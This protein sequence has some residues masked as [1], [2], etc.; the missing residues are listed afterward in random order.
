MTRSI[1]ISEL[2]ELIHALEMGKPDYDGEDVNYDVSTIENA[3][4]V[5]KQ[6]T[7]ILRKVEEFYAKTKRDNSFNTVDELKAYLTEYRSHQLCLAN[8]ILDM[9]QEEE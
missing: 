6:Y 1:H 4:E 9:L 2:E 7:E 8:Q 5:I 3:V